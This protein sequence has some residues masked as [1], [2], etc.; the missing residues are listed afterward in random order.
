MTET[1]EPVT[2]EKLDLIKSVESLLTDIKSMQEDSKA[3]EATS[4]YWLGG[5]IAWEFDSEDEESCDEQSAMFVEWPNLIIQA[6]N[7][8]LALVEFKKGIPE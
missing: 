5:F 6:A 4:P 8:E 7:V 3:R 2:A 1:F